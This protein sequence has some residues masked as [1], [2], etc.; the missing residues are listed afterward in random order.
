[1]LGGRGAYRD[2]RYKVVVGRCCPG[3]TKRLFDWNL[4][5]VAS[6]QES[7]EVVDGVAVQPSM[8]FLRLHQGAHSYVSL[9]AHS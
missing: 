9:G 8:H 4:P 5:Y 2:E 1:M 7:E 6:V 3:M